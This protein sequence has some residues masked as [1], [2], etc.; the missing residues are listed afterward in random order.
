M[1]LMPT[2]GSPL[3][4]NCGTTNLHLDISSAVNVM[5][6]SWELQYMYTLVHQQLQY[7]TLRNRVYRYYR[8]TGITG[9]LGHTAVFL[10]ICRCVVVYIHL[11]LVVLLLYIGVQE[12][13]SNWIV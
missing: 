8:Y 1:E 11:S 5:V 2:V 4:P 3:Y 13:I 10:F 7:N 9:I 6:S 12:Y